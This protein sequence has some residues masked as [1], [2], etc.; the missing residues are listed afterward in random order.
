VRGA[1]AIGFL[2]RKRLLQ[3]SVFAAVGTGSRPML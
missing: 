3:K 1:T 2:E